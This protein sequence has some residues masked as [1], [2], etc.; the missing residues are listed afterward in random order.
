[1]LSNTIYEN[2]Y[3]RLEQSTEPSIP[4]YLILFTK[5]PAISVDHMPDEALVQFGP[6]LKICY[7]AINTVIKPP[8]IYCCSFGEVLKQVH[9]HILPRTE[10]MEKDFKRE[11]SSHQAAMSE[12]INGPIMFEWARQYYKDNTKQPVQDVE[13]VVLQLKAFFIK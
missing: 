10:W 12:P 11:H 6:L 5:V 4:G 13:Q 8:R 7:A 9:F 1:M 3:F 2:E